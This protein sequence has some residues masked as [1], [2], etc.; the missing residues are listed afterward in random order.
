MVMWLDGTDTG[1][2]YTDSGCSSGVSGN[3]QSVGCWEDKSGNNN[4][5]TASG[6]DR[7]TYD[8]GSV[9]FVGSA[10]SSA[11]G[12]CFDIPTQT[13]QTVFLVVE[14]ATDS[15]DGIHGILGE[16]GTNDY[17][18]LSTNKGYTVSFDGAGSATGRVAI[19]NGAFT[20]AGGNVELPMSPP[21][22]RFW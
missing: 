20:S 6:G 14:N 2:M 17:L 5:A 1:T 16:T 7:P 21:P 8:T 11:T 15:T 18:F 12:Q 3:G 4:D 19:N 10:N 22:N 13:A 9:D